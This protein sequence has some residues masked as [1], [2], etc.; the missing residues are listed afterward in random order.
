MCELISLRKRWLEYGFYGMTTLLL[1][2][3]IGS[4]TYMIRAGGG[5]LPVNGQAA[6]FAATNV[7]GKT[8]SF[9]HLD[10]KIRLLTFFYTH[11][12][13][14]CPLVS[15]RLEQVQDQLKKEGVF[16]TKVAIVSVTLDPEHDTLPLVRQ[17]ADRYHPDYQGWY[18]VRPNPSQ[19]P[20]ILK[21]WGVQ[22]Q[23]VPGTVYISHTIKT[24]LIDQNGN[25]RATYPGDNPN[26]DQVE[27]D[28]N[29]LLARWNWVST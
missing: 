26:P 28:I 8:V 20:Q 2:G 14:P 16:G 15:F 1:I 4:I 5:A 9:N 3:I 27:R 13:G 18:F 24:V 17:W 7:N 22:K 21:A 29:G 23:V 6:N 10:G 25:I 12:P 11:C 19:L